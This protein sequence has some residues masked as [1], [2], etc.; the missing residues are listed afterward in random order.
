MIQ[1]K[2]LF[3]CQFNGKLVLPVFRINRQIPKSDITD[4]TSIRII[5]FVFFRII[6]AVAQPS[7]QFL[8][9]QTYSQRNILRN[10]Q[11]IVTKNPISTD[12]IPVNIRRFSCHP[13][14]RQNPGANHPIS[15]RIRLQQPNPAILLCQINFSENVIHIFAISA[16]N[17]LPQ[18]IGHNH[19]VLGS[20][21]DSGRSREK[22]IGKGIP[23]NT[24]TKL[25]H[26]PLLTEKV[27]DI[28]G[29]L[30]VFL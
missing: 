23:D 20:C 9:P 5:P 28:Q 10:R 19:E 24:D 25:I 11:P 21:L 26:R 13:A 29:L 12:A 16:V 6:I 18:H 8:L 3:I 7:R 30:P 15:F 1:I 27:D 14:F 17:G 2:C 22:I 4:I